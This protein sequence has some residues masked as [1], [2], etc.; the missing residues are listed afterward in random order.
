MGYM[1]LCIL[2]PNWKHEVNI[3][4]RSLTD[5]FLNCIVLLT[6]MQIFSISLSKAH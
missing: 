4:L 3:K 6:I 2:T 5:L 1:T